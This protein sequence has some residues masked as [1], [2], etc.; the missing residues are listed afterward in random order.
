MQKWRA[1]IHGFI[2]NPIGLG[3]IILAILFG[4]AA[5]VLW[6]REM[7]YAHPGPAIAALALTVVILIVGLVINSLK[8]ETPD[9]MP[10]LIGLELLVE[11]WREFKPK[12][13]DS[14]IL[15]EQFSIAQS[16]AQR[17]YKQD[18]RFIKYFAGFKIK[19]GAFLVQPGAN[20]PRVL[21]FDSVANMK[22]EIDR[23]KHCVS[24]RLGLT[25]GEPVI[26]LQRHGTIK[27]QEWGAITYNLIGANQADLGRLQTL[28]EYYLRRDDPQQI[29]NALNKVFET[30]RPWWANPTWSDICARRRRNTLYGEYD[31]LTRKQNQIQQGIAEAGRAMQIEALQNITANDRH[32]DL[33]SNLRLRNPL[34]WVRDIF[35]AQQLANWIKRVELRRDSIVHGDLHTGNIL[36]SEG[37]HAQ[38]RAWVID[39]PHT[40]VGPTIQDVARLEADL[41]FSLLPDDTL[42]A[43]NLN[44]LYDFETSLLPPFKRAVP[45]FADL[46]PD[47]LPTNQQTNPQLQKTWEIV[48]LLRGEAKEYMI[49]DDARPYYL[50]LF[51]ATLPM[52]YYRNLSSSQKLYVFISAALLCERL[53]G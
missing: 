9:S 51:H 44:D 15:S 33:D 27:G 7:S 18:I 23:Y 42:Q 38:L 3:A 34:N 13:P 37:E 1:R 31:R 26:P 45:S 50:A 48:C 40:H 53:G 35:G 25:P 28:A 16:I 11:R 5:A 52:L 49:G 47:Q 2:L 22:A 21:K 19:S 36:I 46:T 30:L 4:L 39:F 12:G 14:A 10:R 29:N 43:L 20:I 24:Q 6:A 41:K 8:L 17:D 32:I